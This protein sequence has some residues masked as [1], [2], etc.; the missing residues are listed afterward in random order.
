MKDTIKNLKARIEQT[1]DKI[2]TEEATKNAYILPFIQM[3]G[4][5]IFNPLE[6]VPE[7]TADIGI[8]KGEKVDF[9]IFKDGQP[10]ILIECKDCRNQLSINYESQ[11]FRYFHTTK[12]EFSILTNGLIYQFYTDLEETN[13]MDNKPFM[14]INVLEPEKINY[15]ELQKFTKANFDASNVRKTADLLKC[16]SAIKRVLMQE[17][18]DPSEDFVRMVFKK[19]DCGGSMFNEKAKEKISPLVKSA[20][21]SFINEKVKANLD[22]A[23]QNTVKAQEITER[24]S[25]TVK[26]DIQTTQEEIDAFNIIKAISTE[27][28]EPGR[29]SLRDAKTYCAIFFDDNN[30]KPICRLFFNT[31]DKLMIAFPAPCLDEKIQI[32]NV[33]ELYKFKDRIKGIISGYIVGENVLPK[34]TCPETKS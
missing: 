20:I 4:Y 31:K 2:Q 1:I 7:F 9:A 6:V 33:Q 22:I 28:V 29:I 11:L 27:I 10:A 21:E 16:T 26:G 3:L 19:M 30:R 32:S 13:K 5:D 23:L 18:S 25:A 15:S 8:K 17:L 14:E 34:Q 12:A 24:E